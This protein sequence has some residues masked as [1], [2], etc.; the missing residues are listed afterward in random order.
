MTEQSNMMEEYIRNLIKN[1][2]STQI[3]ELNITL[4]EEDASKIILAI[5]PHLDDLIAKRMKQHFV[6]LADF[7]KN[8]FEKGGD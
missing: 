7:I 4:K 5:L 8:K 1:E 6:E 2:L 3:E